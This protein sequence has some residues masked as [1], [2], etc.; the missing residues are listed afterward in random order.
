MNG[1]F[2]RVRCLRA[3]VVTIGSFDGVHRGHQAIIR[4]ALQRAQALGV[5][6]VAVTFDRHPQESIQPENAP[7]WLTSLTTRLRL[8]LEAGVHDV[9]VLRFDRDFAQLS[10]EAFLQFI[11]QAHLNARC[12]VVGRDFRFGHQRQGSVDY[13]REVQS[14]FGYE[15]EA[16]PDVLYAG[17][18]ISSSRIRQALREGEVREA[19]AM[20]GRAYVLEGV[21]V[22]GQQLGRKL[23][24]P[25]VNLRP[26]PSQL[27]PKDGIY[28]GRLLHPRTGGVYTAAI[29]IGVR[30]TVDGTRRTIEAYLL[31][32]SGNLYGEEVHLAFFYRLRDE[33]KFDSLHALK[34]QMDRDVQQVTELMR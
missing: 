21:V 26:H 7:P 11:L 22:R 17:E 31:G 20:L 8:L 18:R 28:A 27:V 13:L 32:F 12:I 14:R 1:S 34:A 33:Q 19:A 5:P 9:L 16:V 10:A 30:P 2:P 3:S 25:T 24:Y 6:A 29:S 4:V 23:G 15:L